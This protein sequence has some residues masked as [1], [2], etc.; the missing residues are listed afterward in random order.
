MYIKNE[1]LCVL[2]MMGENAS[3]ETNESE[4][5]QQR[6]RN[7][8]KWPCIRKIKKNNERSK[9]TDVYYSDIRPN[10]NILSKYAVCMFIE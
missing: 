5:Q 4:K 7:D 10:S 1:Y 6:M 8:A 3:I 2:Q 9:I